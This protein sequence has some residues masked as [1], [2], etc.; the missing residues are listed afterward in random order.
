MTEKDKFRIINK[1]IR[2]HK[3]STLENRKSFC[4]ITADDKTIHI[5]NDIKPFVSNDHWNKIYTEDNFDFEEFEEH[6]W[7]FGDELFFDIARIT[8]R[9]KFYKLADN[10]IHYPYRKAVYF[11]NEEIKSVKVMVFENLNF[12]VT[13]YS[14]EK[15]DG[16]SW[17][18]SSKDSVSNLLPMNINQLI[19]E[20]K[21][22]TDE[23]VSRELLR[24]I[25]DWQR[26]ILQTRFK[27]S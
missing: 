9:E 7:M 3:D 11:E 1:R 21:H 12:G 17:D 19:F 8:R 15:I 25:D 14:S 20:I 22:Y 26:K 23:K 27:H 4:T 5:V 24:G 16:I 18:F 13:F 10:I 6:A 2:E